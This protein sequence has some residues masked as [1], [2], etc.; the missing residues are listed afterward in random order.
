MKDVVCVYCNGIFQVVRR[1]SHKYCES[2]KEAG[3]KNVSIEFSRRWKLANPDYVNPNSTKEIKALRSKISRHKREKKIPHVS[4][5]W[6]AKERA[7]KYELP[8]DLTLDDLIIPDNCPVLGIP[9]FKNLGNKSPGPNSP[10]VDRI[11]PELGYV[12]G[13]I[14]IISFKANTMKNNAS[15]EE[16]LKFADWVNIN[17][18]G[19]N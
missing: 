10:T 14:Q 7:N 17:F 8:F 18:G 9:L 12:R 11:V 15:I 13:N 16:L 2:C 1:G 19:V 5:Y 4:L 3:Y 6:K